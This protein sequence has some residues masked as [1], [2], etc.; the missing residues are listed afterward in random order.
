MGQW[1]GG[2]LFLEMGGELKSSRGD[3]QVEKD[4]SLI[5]GLG[6]PPFLDHLAKLIENLAAVKQ[7]AMFGL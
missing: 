5:S 4:A 3:H 1:D 6:A 7:F 2:M